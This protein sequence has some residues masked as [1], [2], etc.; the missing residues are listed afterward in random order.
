MGTR[1]IALF[2]GAALPMACVWLG[3]C[4]ES[5][6]VATETATSAPAARIK[7]SST[8]DAVGAEGAN[9]PIDA[10]DP[11]ADRMTTA[12]TQEPPGEVEASPRPQT[13]AV[14]RAQADSSQPS[15]LASA[16]FSRQSAVSG[17]KISMRTPRI[18]PQFA[19]WTGGVARELDASSLPTFEPPD[20]IGPVAFDAEFAAAIDRANANSSLFHQLLE[21]PLP[22]QRDAG[23]MVFVP[24]GDTIERVWIYGVRWDGEVFRGKVE[25][26]TRTLDGLFRHRPAEIPPELVVDWYVLIGEVVV[27]GETLAIDYKRGSRWGRRRIEERYG[28]PVVYRAA[29]TFSDEPGR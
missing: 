23:V 10:T 20:Q 21:N 15:P 18:V 13:V 24:N 17:R 1:P 28:A 22:R 6:E 27:G 14:A 25:R 16:R 7:S 11:A 4:L 3:G 12:P 8:P 5:S 26:S 29:A 19:D 2:V 9:E